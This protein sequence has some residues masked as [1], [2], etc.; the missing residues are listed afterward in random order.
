MIN[1]IVKGRVFIK[2]VKLK[3]LFSFSIDQIGITTFP[4][5]Y[6]TI[7]LYVYT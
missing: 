1:K 7:T 4:R 6:T 5:P 2:K 3:K